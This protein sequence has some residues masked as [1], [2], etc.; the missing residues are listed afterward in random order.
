MQYGKIPIIF[1]AAWGP[2]RLVEILFP[3]TKPILSFPDWNVD[4]IIRTMKVK[5]KVCKWFLVG[6]SLSQA[7]RVNRGKNKTHL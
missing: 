1:A 5:A 7:C 3:W 4:A 2:R 6:I